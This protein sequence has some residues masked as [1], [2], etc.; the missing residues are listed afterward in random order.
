MCSQGLR[1]RGP[2]RLSHACIARAPRRL[3]ITCR[4]TRTRNCRKRLRRECCGPVS[5]DVMRHGVECTERQ[6]RLRGDASLCRGWRGQRSGRSRARFVCVGGAPHASL[7]H[8][9]GSLTAVVGGHTLLVPADSVSVGLV[10][11]RVAGV[12]A[13]LVSSKAMPPFTFQHLRVA[14]TATHNWSP[15]ADTQRMKAASRQVLRAGQ[16]RRYEAWR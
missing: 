12:P 2:C 4:S 11:A 5:S 3:H 9:W 7:V 14:T 16:L 13:W 10:G 8:G 6:S 1:L 15:D